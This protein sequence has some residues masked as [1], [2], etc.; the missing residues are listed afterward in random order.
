MS[1]SG[2]STG[3]AVGVSNHH[4]RR[5][6]EASSPTSDLNSAAQTRTKSTSDGANTADTTSQAQNTFLVLLGSLAI[7]GS[8]Q[9]WCTDPFSNGISPVVIG[10]DAYK[11]QQSLFEAGFAGEQS[12]SWDC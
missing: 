11:T 9:K 4:H 8:P 7:N 2:I 12:I 1:I 10:G 3:T 6:Q 5:G